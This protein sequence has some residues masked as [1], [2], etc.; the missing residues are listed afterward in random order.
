MVDPTIH[1]IL[2]PM[3]LCLIPNSWSC[4]FGWALPC[5]V[6]SQTTLETRSTIAAPLSWCTLRGWSIR[7]GGLTA[8]SS[9]T[10]AAHWVEVLTAEASTSGGLGIVLESLVHVSGTEGGSLALASTASSSVVA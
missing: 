1:E 9:K 4:W 7:A 10:S 6:V 3:R 2:L 5:K 8:C